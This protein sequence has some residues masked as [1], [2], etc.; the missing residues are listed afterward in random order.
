[1]VLGTT[2]GAG[3]STVVTALCRALARRGV[4]VAPFK[5]Q[6]MSNHSAVTSDGGELGRAQAMQAVA[7]RAELDRRMGPVLLKPSGVHTSHVVVMGEEVGVDEAADFGDRVERVRPVVL[8]ALTSLRRDHE[9]VVLE[10]AGGAAEINLLDRDVVNLPLAAAAGLPAVLVVDIDRGGSFASAYGTWALLPERLRQHLRGFVVNSFRGDAGLLEDGL[11]DLEARTG[12]P[13]L[14]VLPHLG[15]HLML[16]IE[17]SLDLS[18]PGRPVSPATA[19]RPVRVAVVRLPHL[20]NPSDLDPLV[21]EP[22]VELRWA[23]RPADIGDADLVVL[24]GTRT[25]VA[26]LAWLRGTGLAE[27]IPHLSRKIRVL[28]ICGGY[29]MLG[30]LI[31]DDLESGAGTVEGLGLLPVETTFERPKVVTRSGGRVLRTGIPVEG[32]QIRFGRPHRTGG[33]PWLELAPWESWGEAEEEGC[34]ARSRLRVRGTSLHG[35]L[36]NDRLRHALLWEVAAARR[37]T[38]EPSEV[39]YRQA[40]EDHVEHLAD[41]VE[42]HLDVD[43]VLALAAEAAAPGEEPGW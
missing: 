14:G 4:D 6:N 15:E 41:W 21:L 10:G 22:C 25:T 38:F 1:M 17:D 34:V 13:V 26:D 39:P 43:A 18:A 42:G 31:H 37:R 8:D 20:S 23:T 19:E 9:V 7:A 32:Y 16:G 12:V 35:V 29:Q 30:E 2:S 24:P 28:G 40:V 36:D 33:Q 11:R 3:K 27:A 5:A